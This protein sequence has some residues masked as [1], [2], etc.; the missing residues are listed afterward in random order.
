M[1]TELCA[2][3]RN[4]F[5]R[6]Q[7]DIHI[8]EYTISGGHIQ[9]LPFL[10][11][12]Q[13][14]RIVGSVFNDGVWQYEVDNLPK[15]ETFEGAIWAMRMPPAVLALSQEIDAWITAN[16]GV[17]DSPYSSESFGGYS[18]A[19]RSGSG[20]GEGSLTWQGQFSKRLSKWRKLHEL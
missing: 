17:I 7:E 2:E 15:D 19:K 14:Y 6:G 10:Q 4:Y 20:E 5:I 3:L 9:S 13:Y 8:G 16:Q 18:Y 12:G 1:L 11:A